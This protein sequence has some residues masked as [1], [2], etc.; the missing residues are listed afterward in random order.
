MSSSHITPSSSPS[1]LPLKPSSI[2]LAIPLIKPALLKLRSAIF[3]CV[4]HRDM[5]TASGGSSP[6]SVDMKSTSSEAV[7][8]GLSTPLPSPEPEKNDHM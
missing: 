1:I 7:E 2:M 4:S 8:L 5:S 3:T 6:K